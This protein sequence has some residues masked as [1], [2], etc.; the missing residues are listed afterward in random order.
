MGE[1]TDL[2]DTSSLPEKSGSPSLRKVPELID[3]FS[4]F[5]PELARA[6]EGFE[7]E[8]F[9]RL[10]N[11]E[12]GSFWFKSRNKLILWA[13]KKYFSSAKNFLEIGCG[14]GFVLSAIEKAFPDMELCGSEIYSKGL[15]F[16]ARRVKRARLFQMDARKIPFEE[17]FDLIG[18]FDVLEHI[19]EDDLVLSEMHRAIKQGGGIIITVPQHKFLWSKVDEHARHVRRY[20]ASELK[21]KVEAAGFSP[22][23]ATSFVSLL[24]PLYAASRVAG[25]FRVS[26]GNAGSDLKPPGPLNSALEGLLDLERFFIKRGLSLPAGSSLLMVAEKSS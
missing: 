18:A 3:G 5:A 26:E 16:A 2:R 7:S 10:F 9:E 15:S 4:A 23:R 13:I 17:E 12:S 22:M 24:L 1:C 21:E 19:K 8:F 6:N 25:R 14:T 11:I 20:S